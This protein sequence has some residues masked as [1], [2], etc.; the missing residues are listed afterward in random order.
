M[1]TIGTPPTI[2]ASRSEEFDT[3]RET[4][5][6]STA[7][8]VLLSRVLRAGCSLGAVGAFAKGRSE[9]GGR[10]LI[11]LSAQP[12]RPAGPC[13]AARM[14]RGP[15]S[16]QTGKRRQRWSHTVRWHATAVQATAGARSHQ[17]T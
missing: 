3:T 6:R 15:A 4:W 5:C 7:L 10:K 13:T 2:G 16:T 12:R 1:R 17:R 14:R 11:A 9:K 8:P